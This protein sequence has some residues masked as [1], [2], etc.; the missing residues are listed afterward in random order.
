LVQELPPPTAYA[1]HAKNGGTLTLP[2]RF[3]HGAYDHIRETTY[4]SAPKEGHRDARMLRERKPRPVL[5][6][7]QCTYCQLPP[8][9]RSAV[10]K[11]KTHFLPTDIAPFF[12][13]VA[14][15][16]LA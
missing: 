9:G 6:A 2:I 3:L 1:A 4:I 16:G 11:Q 13:C 12:S 5:G 14:R 7:W 8:G 15:K 10:G